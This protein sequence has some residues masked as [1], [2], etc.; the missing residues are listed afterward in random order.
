MNED[1]R[2]MIFADSRPVIHYDPPLRPRYVGVSR[3]TVE[4]HNRARR[5]RAVAL[6]FAIHSDIPHIL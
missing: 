1:V 6:F 5:A 3:G 4:P 2:C